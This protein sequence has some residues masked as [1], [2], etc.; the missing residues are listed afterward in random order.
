MKAI[1]IILKKGTHREDHA[2]NIVKIPYLEIEGETGNPDDVLLEQWPSN[3]GTL[4]INC[5]GPV[6]VTGIKIYKYEC[7]VHK[8]VLTV[9]ECRKISSYSSTQMETVVVQNGMYARQS[10]LMLSALQEG[11]TF[12]NVK[13]GP[14]TRALK[15][16]RARSPCAYHVCILL[17]MHPRRNTH[18]A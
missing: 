10:D 9:D 14:I 4:E 11:C 1:R 3:H 13:S 12:S 15:F 2:D 7:T 17:L 5:N 18:C 16:A 8:S 6:K